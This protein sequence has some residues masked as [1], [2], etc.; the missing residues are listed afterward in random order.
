MITESF[1][2]RSREII[3]P[4]QAVPPESLALAKEWKM[5]TFI[6]FFSHNLLSTLAESG[7]IEP[8][9]PQLRIGS[10]AG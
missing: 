1:D 2:P 9:H 7:A 8:L 4:E 10:A 6:V 5:E 3:T